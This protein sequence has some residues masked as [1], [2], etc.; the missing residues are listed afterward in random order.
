MR[1]EVAKFLRFGA[2][3]VVGVGVFRLVGFLEEA[4]G[5]TE[6]FVG[7]VRFEMV[8]LDWWGGLGTSVIR[9]M[10]VEIGFDRGRDRLSYRVSAISRLVWRV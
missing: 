7:C 5:K 1:G 2:W 4:E 8:K 9:F 6:I 3:V 10:R